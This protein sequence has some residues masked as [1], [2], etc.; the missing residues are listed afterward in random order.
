MAA[1]RRVYDSRHLQADCQ[2]PVSAA[3]YGRV[4]STFTVDS[5]RRPHRCCL[6]EIKVQN[7]DRGLSGQSAPFRGDLGPT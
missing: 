4:W 3:E 1:Y 5:E 7:I 2:E 6:L